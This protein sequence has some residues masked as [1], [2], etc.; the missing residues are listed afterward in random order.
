MTAN[1]AEGYIRTKRFLRD[2]PNW[3]DVLRA[4]LSEAAR[5]KSEFAG[6]WVLNE[7]KKHG[8]DWFPNLRPL[9]SYGLLERTDVTRGGRRA[10]YIFRDI[11]GVNS[12]LVEATHGLEETQV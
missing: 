10:Y 2:H 7:A 6:A 1:H 8:R 12:A 9:V 4:C 11:D 5:T 3:L